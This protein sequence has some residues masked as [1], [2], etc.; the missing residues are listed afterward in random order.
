MSA[1][2]SNTDF[3]YRIMSFSPHGALVQMFVIEA[4]RQYSEA[5]ADPSVQV[6]D[7]ALLSGQAWKKTAEWVHAQLEQHLSQ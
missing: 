7:T 3:M 2:E 6:P 1:S 4:L 5:V